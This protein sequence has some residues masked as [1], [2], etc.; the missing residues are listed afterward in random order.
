MVRRGPLPEGAGAVVCTL[1]GA[2]AAADGKGTPIVLR[3]GAN[4]PDGSAI[5]GTPTRTDA[6]VF[7]PALNPAD[8]AVLMADAEVWRALATLLH[9][10]DHTLPLPPYLVTLRDALDRALI[11]PL[12]DLT[13]S[14][15]E[16]KE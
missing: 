11:P 14:T 16:P 13:P 12:A 7:W 9:L 3:H 8:R 6:L 1:C 10:H 4:C 5:I 15:V 2:R